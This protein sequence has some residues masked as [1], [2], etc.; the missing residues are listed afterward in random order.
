MKQFLALLFVFA[1]TSPLYAQETIVFTGLPTIKISEGGISRVSDTLSKNKSLEY[2]CTITK[3]DDKYY[4]ATR[5]NVELVPI[6]GGAF[7]TFLATNGSGYI[8]IVSLDMKEVV[9]LMGETEGTFDYVEHLMFGLKTIT[10]YGK[11]K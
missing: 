11:A 10:Y 6:Q 3:I 9:S 7:I 8:R 5:E 4:W 2:K 1:L